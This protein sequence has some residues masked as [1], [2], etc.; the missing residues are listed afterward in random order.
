MGM[1]GTFQRGT[2]AYNGGTIHLFS[3]AGRNGSKIPFSEPGAVIRIRIREPVVS[4]DVGRG[5]V[6]AIRQV[7]ATDSETRA[8]AS[9]Y[10]LPCFV[11]DH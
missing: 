2:N 7:A 3:G 11:C 1:P 8:S 6:R 4:V 10:R 5:D 9:M